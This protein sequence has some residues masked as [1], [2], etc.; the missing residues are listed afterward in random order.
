MPG[1][2]DRRSKSS[3]QRL[4]TKRAISEGRGAA[5]DG[6]GPGLMTDKVDAELVAEAGRDIFDCPAEVQMQLGAS[7]ET[8][9]QVG[10]R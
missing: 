2:S 3:K 7:L 1:Q 5:L 9:M 8:S 10:T 4:V 6:F